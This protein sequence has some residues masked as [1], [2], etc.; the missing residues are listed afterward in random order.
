MWLLAEYAPT[1]LFSLKSSMATS[2]GAR[3]NLC[4]TMYAV[5][6][7]LIAAAFEAGED[8]EHVFEVVKSLPIRFRPAKWAVINNAF[9]KVQ[10]Q[11]HDRSQP[12]FQATVGYREYVHLQ[13][14]LTVAV[15]VEGLRDCEVERLGLL[16]KV[17]SYLGKRGGFMQ[18]QGLSCVGELGA[19]FTYLLGEERAQLGA[20]VIVQFLDDF[21]PGVTFAAINSYSE[22]TARLGRDR[23]IVPVALPC[24]L[25]A[26]S[27]TYSLYERTGE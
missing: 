1:A 9:V 10:R 13:G 17:V 11:P 6:M 25:R 15:R 16:L 26:S 19:G 2:S 12:G 21:G 20:D 27:R 22:A 14:N 18:F 23:V 7:A 3:S 8:G 24:R 5:K 4:P